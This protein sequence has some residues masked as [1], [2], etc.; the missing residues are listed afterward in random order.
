MITIHG[1]KDCIDCFILKNWLII[2]EIPFEYKELNYGIVP[3]IVVDNEEG[4]VILG[5]LDECL[6]WIE[7][8]YNVKFQ[9]NGRAC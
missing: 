9:D 4:F 2:Y 7:I 3:R 1:M 8:E 6:A 5:G